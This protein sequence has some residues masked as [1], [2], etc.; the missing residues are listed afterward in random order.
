[1]DWQEFTALLVL[2]TAM[3]FSPGPNTTLSTALAA[4]GGLKRAMRF[5]VAVPVGWTL[6]L[7]LCAAGIGSLVVAVPALRLVIK[8]L[9]IAYLLWLAWKLSRS[10]TLGSA[11]EAQLSV[12][13][14]QGVM[15]QFINIKAWLLALTL[16]AGW[17]AGQPDALGRFAIVAPVMLFYAFASNLAYAVVGAVLRSWL[18]KGKRLL[19]FNRGMAAV[20]VLTAWWMVG[21]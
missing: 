18:T 21:V 13:F 16:V 11:D 3:S 6:L 8:A 17:I 1:M 20:L 9:G 10:A 15:L 4:N 2:A 19:W 5:I 14:V 7:M 12:G